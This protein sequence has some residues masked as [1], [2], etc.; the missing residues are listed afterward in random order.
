VAQSCKHFEKCVSYNT[1]KIGHGWPAR[2]QLTIINHNNTSV[3]NL[4]ITSAIVGSSWRQV[5]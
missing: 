2:K 5:S 1:P 3:V 4:K